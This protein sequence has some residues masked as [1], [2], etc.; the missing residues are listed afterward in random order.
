MLEEESLLGDIDAFG[1]V[2]D[3][4]GSRRS[5]PTLI[6][7][8]GGTEVEL[9]LFRELEARFDAHL[10]IDFGREVPKMEIGQVT[11]EG[12][13][14]IREAAGLQPRTLKE[15][16]REAILQALETVRED[17]IVNYDPEDEEIRDIIQRVKGMGGF[18]I[19]ECHLER[20]EEPSVEW[21]GGVTASIRNIR[22]FFGIL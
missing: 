21:R 4:F 19:E 8:C 6:F 16:E 14:P 2:E 15:R 17:V 22:I 1:L 11:A 20:G 9:R 10:K 5:T 7:I 12:I 3:P 13:T 18:T